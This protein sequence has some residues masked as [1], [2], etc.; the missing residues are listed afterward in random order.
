M[1]IVSQTYTDTMMQPI[2]PQGEVFVRWTLSD[3]TVKEF[4]DDLLAQS[5]GLEYVASLSPLMTELPKNTLK[6][7]FLDVDNEYNPHD[8]TSLLKEIRPKQ[9]VTLVYRQYFDDGTYEDVEVDTLLTTGEVSVQNAVVT[10]YC[11]D[12]LS[13]A[14]IGTENILTDTIFGMQSLNE[15][16][17]YDLI[18]SCI[19]ALDMNYDIRNESDLRAMTTTLVPDTTINL[20]Q[21][22]QLLCEASLSTYRVFED[23]V[24]IESI[25]II[26]DE[27]SYYLSLEEMSEDP[28]VTTSDA[29]RSVTVNYYDYAITGEET[30]LSKFTTSPSIHTQGYYT[31]T[32]TLTSEN[33]FVYGGVRYGGQELDD[34]SVILYQDNAYSLNITLNFH[35]TG[36]EAFDVDSLSVYGHQIQRVTHSTSYPASSS[37]ISTTGTDKTIDNP[38][39]T[40]FDTARSLAMYA[41]N[42]LQSNNGISVSYRGE[43]SVQV[44]DTLMADTSYEENVQCLVARNTIN[45]DGGLSGSIEL[46]RSDAE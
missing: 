37:L 8:P 41:Y 46:I 19:G 39:V 13:F 17:Y 23:T 2:R 5:D 29:C 24:I 4:D 20:V 34:Y 33:A 21:Q 25:G 45:W 9:N 11:Q 14:D 10:I 3:G 6:F 27:S 32:D 38:Y 31:I 12:R 43:P 16:T 30:E 7:S 1:I 22:L 35:Y 40:S 42:S 36:T 18:V 15:H 44:N 28:Q 26:N